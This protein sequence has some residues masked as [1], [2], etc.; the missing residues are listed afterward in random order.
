MAIID[1]RGRRGQRGGAQTRIVMVWSLVTRARR[2]GVLS[3]TLR[4]PDKQNYM[5]MAWITGSN[6]WKHLL[7]GFAIGLASSGWHCA[8]LAGIAA[9]GALEYKDRAYGSKWDWWDFSL[10]VAGAVAGQAVARLAGL[11]YIN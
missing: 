11:P 2:R 4:K 6:R 1:D 3:P 5:D 7:G 10:T 9:G 8:A